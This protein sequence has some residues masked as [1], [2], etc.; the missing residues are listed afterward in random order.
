MGDL[1]GSGQI[2]WDEFRSMCRRVLKLTDQDIHLRYVF[3]KLDGDDS[4]EI[5]IEELISFVQDTAAL[6]KI[7]KSALER[8]NSTVAKGSPRYYSARYQINMDTRN[9]AYMSDRPVSSYQ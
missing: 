4:G 9:F 7:Q 1:D 3:Q 8:Q 2:S 5:S 6:M